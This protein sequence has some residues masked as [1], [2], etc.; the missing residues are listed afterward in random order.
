M[1]DDGQNAILMQMMKAIGSIDANQDNLQ[2]QI[3]DFKEEYK[4]GRE[5]AQKHAATLDI[6]LVNIETSNVRRDEIKFGLFIDNLVMHWGW[7]LVILAIAAAIG[8]ITIG[9]KWKDAVKA[10]ETVEGGVES[11]IRGKVKLK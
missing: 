6:R 1:A 4:S 8:F 9:D 2:R 11:V 10:K 3:Q 7:V 5:A